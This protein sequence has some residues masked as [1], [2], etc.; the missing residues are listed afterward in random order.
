MRQA[1]KEKANKT[2][3]VSRRSGNNTGGRAAGQPQQ[4]GRGELQR[5]KEA[6]PIRIDTSFALTNTYNRYQVLTRTGGNSIVAT[7]Q[8]QV[9]AIADL[10]PHISKL[11]GFKSKKNY[12][13]NT[14]PAVVLHDLLSQ[15]EDHGSFENWNLLLR[16]DTYTIKGTA[17]YGNE[18]PNWVTMDYLPLIER[19]HPELHELLFYAMVLVSQYNGIETF[20]DC[21]ELSDGRRGWL[22]ETLTESMEYYI[23]DNP[24]P[25][26]LEKYTE[27]WHNYGPNGLP[28]KYIRKI[29]GG[30]S[31]R[32]FKSKL[33][34]FVPEDKIGEISLPY[35]KLALELASTKRSILDFSEEPYEGGELTPLHYKRF[36]WSDDER[37]YMWQNLADHI[38]AQ[39][40][41]GVVP[42]CWQQDIDGSEDIEKDRKFLD[43]VESFFKVAETTANLIT[44]LI[45]NPK[46]KTKK[47]KE[48]ELLIN[49]L[50]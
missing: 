22:Y 40:Q 2:Q 31:L 48:N 21:V 34:E 9:K 41:C 12:T 4:D 33:S 13:A 18:D 1:N 23:G 44:Q 25:D 30:G 10:Y 50:A 36:V 16:G 42:F 7:P 39:A 29:R 5:A 43:L 32:L 14:E 20:D 19:S 46:R 24:E 28:A 47:Q 38:D 8:Q 6:A 15:F 45:K 3:R 11:K 27:T 35:L 49:I 17:F 37:D 26:A